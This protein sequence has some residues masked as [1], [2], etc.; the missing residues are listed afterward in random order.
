[1]TTSELFD[2]LHNLNRAD[3]LRAMQLLVQELAQEDNVTLSTPP[4]NE[5]AWALHESYD[6][7]DAM[8]KILNDE[9]TPETT[10]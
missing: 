4:I 6:V 8:L 1:M 10:P 5:A 2:A 7:A 3:K 9:L